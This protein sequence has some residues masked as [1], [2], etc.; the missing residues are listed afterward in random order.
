MEKFTKLKPPQ[1]NKKDKL[2]LFSNDYMDI[3]EY[4]GWSIIKENDFVVCVLYLIELNQLIFRYEYIPTF[5]YA[6]GQEYHITVISGSVESGESKETSL[7][8]EIEEE[9]G[10]VI[11]PEFKIEFTRPFFISKGHSSKFHPAIITLTEKDYHEVISNGDGSK[12]EKLSKS[13]KIDAKYID[14]I[15]P[16]DLITAFMILK[17]KEYLNME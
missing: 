6:E 3:I 9:A 5:K 16:S 1:E 12:A 15:I 4:E 8:R 17:V 2:P 13:I 10:I 7:I 14:S 11:D